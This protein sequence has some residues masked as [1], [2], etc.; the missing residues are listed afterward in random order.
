MKNKLSLK[1]NIIANYVSQLYVAA[2]GILILPLYIKYM[3]AEAYGLVGFFTMLQAWFAL[4]DLGLTPTIGRETARYHGGAMS[5]L[6]YRQLFRALSMIFCCIAVVGGSGLWLLSGVIA[7]HWLEVSD[8][9][10]SEVI[11]AIQIMTIS[12][13]FR[14][15]GGLY[16]GVISGSERL[17]WLSAFNALI[18]TLRFV[19]VF[20]S[21][22]FYGFTPYVFFMH[23]LAI[24]LLEI[25]GLFLMSRFLL[26]S[27]II[28]EQH[29][30]WSIRP[31]KPFLKFALTI[32][33]T[34]SVWVL[35]TQTD[36]LILS[37]ILPLAEYGYFTLA[38]LVASGIMVI[39][40]PI[41]NAIMP[42]MARLYAEGEH[43]EM[44]K[45]YRHATRLVSVIAG[46][47][48]IT[49]AA[50]AEQ[51]LFAWT[52]DMQVA[53]KAA[54]ILRLYAIGN[55]FLSIAAFPYY[56]QYALGDLRYHLIGNVVT[57]ILLIPAVIVAA[58]NFGAI[59]AAYVWLGV[60]A[61]NVFIWG[62][63]VHSKLLPG[64][65]S[66]WLLK[67]IFVNIFPVLIIAFLLYFFPFEVEGRGQNLS[68]LLMVGLSAFLSSAAVFLYFRK[69]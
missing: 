51:L 48:S 3:G 58:I 33:F 42:R 31:V 56:L 13:A 15:M 10:L 17:V 67:D 69:G 19:A 53:E 35:V 64:V 30:G 25:T 28:L 11:L 43:A 55:G 2:V 39:S 21:M 5:A 61:F 27:R 1:K 7:T 49:I 66:A 24:A 16:R 54:P 65:H 60:N 68:F 23:Q 62:A 9:P 45:V 8:L 63:F 44:L 6:A 36:K 18:A 41:S 20:A 12:V 38:V 46:S 47:A 26:P 52:G 59:G 50:S 22:W 34:S 32:A 40:G 57:I 14:W 4:L 29:I 37:G